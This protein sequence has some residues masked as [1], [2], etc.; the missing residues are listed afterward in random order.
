[1]SVVTSSE[2]HDMRVHMVVTK[3]IRHGS[4]GDCP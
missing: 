1:M 4:Y 2:G 3:K